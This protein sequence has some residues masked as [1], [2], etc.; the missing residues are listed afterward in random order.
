MARVLDISYIPTGDGWLYL[1]TVL[2]LEPRRLLGYSM[3]THMCTSL[4]RDALDDVADDVTAGIVFHPDR[5]SQYISLEFAQV[6]SDR[7]MVQFAG[8]IR[9]CRDDSVAESFF[10]SLRRE[11]VSR[12]G[13]KTVPAHTG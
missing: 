8:R 4:I 9:Q 3:A 5:G 10:I 1:A 11:L 12:Y 7:Q 6:I 2:D 13:S